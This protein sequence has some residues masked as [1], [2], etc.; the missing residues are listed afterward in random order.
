VNMWWG[1][2]W[3]SLQNNQNNEHYVKQK[4]LLQPKHRLLGNVAYSN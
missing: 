1:D 3:V 2:L 4:S